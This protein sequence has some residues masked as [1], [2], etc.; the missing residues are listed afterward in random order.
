M[1]EY[2]SSNKQI[3]L[4]KHFFIR[5]A[6]RISA[7]TNIA[8]VKQESKIIEIIRELI[9]SKKYQLIYD[10]ETDRNIK[11]RMVCKILNK[12][13]TLAVIDAPKALIFKSIWRA[14]RWEEEVYEEVKK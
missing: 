13:S 11:Y 2:L 7:E 6:R 12:T 8:R 5:W 3:V 14:K 9:T 4:T 1:A 10:G